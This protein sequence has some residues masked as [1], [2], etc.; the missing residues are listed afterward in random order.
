MKRINVTKYGIVPN[1][2]DLLTNKIQSLIDSLSDGGEI[3]FPR[4]KYVLSTI[5]LRDNITINIA[6][7][8][9]L[10]GSLNFNDYLDRKANFLNRLTF[11]QMLRCGL[12]RLNL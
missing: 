11:Q 7:G 6:E 3:Y 2:D 4:G 9:T 10:L 12:S 5:V 1:T 8:A